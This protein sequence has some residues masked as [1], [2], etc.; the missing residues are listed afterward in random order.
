VILLGFFDS[1]SEAKEIAKKIMEK[2]ERL[3]FL[4]EIIGELPSGLV[5]WFANRL[6]TARSSS[7]YAEIDFVTSID[8]EWD[9]FPGDLVIKKDRDP[10]QNDVVD[11]VQRTEEDYVVLTVR[12]LKVNVKEGTVFVSRVIDSDAKGSIPIQNILRVIDR[13][14][15]LG[16]TEWKKLVSLFDLD[17]NK[18]EIEG[19]IESSLETVKKTDGFYQKE[20]A[21]KKLEEHLKEVKGL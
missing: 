17:Y 19:W 12:V 4:Y 5:H 3:A 13:V 18:N 6:S 10:K 8:M 21:I 2:E 15:P 9:A 14:I 1:K 7:G 20:K 11:I 16:S